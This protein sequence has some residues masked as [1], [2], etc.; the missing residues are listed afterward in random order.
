MVLRIAGRANNILLDFS[1]FVKDIIRRST[2]GTFVIVDRHDRI[3]VSEMG[4]KVPLCKMQGFGKRGKKEGGGEREGGRT[5]EE[6]DCGTV[7]K[8]PLNIPEA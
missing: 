7:R 8:S 1:D 4:E 5:G 3:L 6:G 2:I